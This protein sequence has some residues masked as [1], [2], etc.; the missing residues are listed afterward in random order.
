[1]QVVGGTPQMMNNS[2]K[3][4]RSAVRS[5]ASKRNQAAKQ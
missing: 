4:K 5:T 3:V 1:M 2:D